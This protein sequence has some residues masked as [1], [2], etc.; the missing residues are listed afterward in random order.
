VLI[1][2]KITNKLLK[3]KPLLT[4]YKNTN[5]VTKTEEKARQRSCIDEDSK[6]RKRRRREPLTL[7]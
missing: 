6:L 5:N 7:D 2:E 4:R 1:C 3:I